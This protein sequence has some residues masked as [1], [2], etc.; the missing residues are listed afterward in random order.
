MNK[1]ELNE[2]TEL[3]LSHAVEFN[4]NRKMPN[5][6][7]F[8][9]HTPIEQKAILAAWAGYEEMRKNYDN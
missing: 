7:T 9:E 2:V 3:F 6:R 4:I 5:I 1:N 8:E